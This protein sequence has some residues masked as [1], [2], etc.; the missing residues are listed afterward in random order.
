[1]EQ[2]NK[3]C[4]LKHREE[5]EEKEEE[6][7]RKRRINEEEEEKEGG[8]GGR[9][10]GKEGGRRKRRKKIQDTWDVAIIQN[11]KKKESSEAEK[12]KIGNIDIQKG[13]I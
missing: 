6:K 9:R 10:R 3:L 8:G 5:E 1:M 11:L 2:V 4:R 12:N 7:K 13:N